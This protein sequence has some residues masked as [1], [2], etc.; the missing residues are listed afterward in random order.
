[1]KFLLTITCMTLSSFAFSQYGP[2]DCVQG[3]WQQ[4]EIVGSKEKINVHSYK[5]LCK[6]KPNGE[7]TEARSTCVGIDGAV[8]SFEECMKESKGIKS[9]NSS[10]GDSFTQKYSEYSAEFAKQQKGTKSQSSG[11]FYGPEDCVQ[12]EWQHKEVSTSKES[13]DLHSY[14][15]LCKSRPNGEI[16]ITQTECIGDGD[17]IPSFAEC[18]AKRNDTLKS[19]N[20]SSGDSLSNRYRELSAEFHKQQGV[21][22]SQDMSDFAYC[23]KSDD[24]RSISCPDGIYVKSSSV[25]DSSRLNSKDVPQKTKKVKT[26]ALGQKAQKQ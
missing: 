12:G 18:M 14:T 10:N 24:G 11:G 1:M 3:E 25:V 20:S 9:K 8:P 2:E 15:I 21:Q 17:K 7:V 22:V 4:R 23:S 13:Y 5:S 6:S 19:K 16:I 26:K